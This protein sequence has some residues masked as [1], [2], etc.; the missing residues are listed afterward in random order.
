[1]Y[2]YLDKLVEYF[3][4]QK[5]TSICGEIAYPAMRIYIFF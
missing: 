3:N 1:M 4:L 2:I 5:N